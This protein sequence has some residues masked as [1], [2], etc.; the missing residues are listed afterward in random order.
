MTT[1]KEK[2]F[3][4]HK[5]FHS[6]DKP[7]ADL[8]IDFEARWKR[9]LADYQNLQKQVAKEKS[10]YAR[11]ANEQLIL[12][13]LPVYEN[14]QAAIEHA[15][16]HNHDQWLQGVKYVIKQLADVLQNN[17]IT[18]INPI[19]EKF[20]PHEHEA[21]EKIEIDDKDKVNKVAQVIRQGYKIGTKVVQ[22]A[23]V[24]VY[25]E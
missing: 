7:K 9:A 19:G 18:I 23:K 5:S 2:K 8:A 24:A 20:N 16:E 25:V 4:E 13:I 1:E 21:I 14:L 3:K 15:D 22:A 11:Y 10:E 6:K 17:G 12:E